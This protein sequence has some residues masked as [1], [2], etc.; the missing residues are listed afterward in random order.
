MNRLRIF[1]YAS[2]FENGE[3]GDS[4]DKQSEPPNGYLDVKLSIDG[5]I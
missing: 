2:A 4:D 1:F 3:L 5:L